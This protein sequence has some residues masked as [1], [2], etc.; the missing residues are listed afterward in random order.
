MNTRQ[1]RHFLAVL[2]L[3]SLSAAAEA[4]H[5]SQPAL[6]RSLSALED[7]LRAPLFDRTGRRLRATPYAL[8][9]AKRARRIVFDANE[10]TR[11]LELMRGGE[12]GRLSFAMGSSLAAW[13]LGPMMLKL[14]QEAPA[15]KLSALI[16]T[17][18]TMVDALI[19]ETL[20]FFVGDISVAALIPDLAAEPVFPCTFSWFARQHHPLARKRRIGI[21][22]LETYTLIGTGHLEETLLR[23]FAQLYS[24]QPPVLDHFGIIADDVA[25]VRR[26][27][28]DSDA[29][30]PA[31]DLSMIDA[32]RAGEVIVLDVNPPLDDLKMT[33]GIV[34]RQ[35]RTLVP[36]ADRAFELIR[37][38]FAEAATEIAR[39]RRRGAS[40]GR[41]LR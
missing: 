26:V 35:G 39:L 5:L 10:G 1:L 31:T 34:R 27:I 20:D 32:L 28:V 3:G 40:A 29:V 14:M 12:L 8:A 21:K 33:L 4:V 25:A 37:A 17:S 6:S 16:K 22:E 41:A 13:L 23:R 36:A 2:D 24:L 9:Y 18:D 15:L 7:E 38:Q 11:E 30:V 19:G